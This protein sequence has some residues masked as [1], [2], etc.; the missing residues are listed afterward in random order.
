MK[1]KCSLGALG[2]L[3][4]DVIKKGDQNSGCDQVTWVL[5]SRNLW[6]NQHEKNNGSFKR[7]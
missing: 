1:K 6:V 3:G 4:N 7:P 5:G 2:A